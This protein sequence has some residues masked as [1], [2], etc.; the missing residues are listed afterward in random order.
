[1]ITTPNVT[2]FFVFGVALNISALLANFAFETYA[3]LMKWK[4]K[5]LNYFSQILDSQEDFTKVSRDMVV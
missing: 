2:K 3:T 5:S 1:M 4:Y